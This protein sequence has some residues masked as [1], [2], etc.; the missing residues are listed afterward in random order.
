[1][2]RS[3][4]FAEAAGTAPEGLAIDLGSGAGLPGLVLASNWP[5]SRWLLVE[6]SERRATFLSDAVHELGLADRVEIFVGSAERVAHSEGVRGQAALV[7]VRSLGPPAGIAECA[8]GFLTLGGTLLVGE[9][10]GSD[11]ARWAGLEST[12]LG[13]ALLSV[14]LGSEPG[15]MAPIAVLR[16]E[17][18][19][20]TR[21]PRRAPAPFRSPLFM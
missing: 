20:P 1:M 5:Q 18:P 9:A 12:D 16:Q 4:S 19:C 17:Q 11:G 10:P 7:T 21:Y 8:A 15:G 14:H 3:L 6:R 2:T 13:L